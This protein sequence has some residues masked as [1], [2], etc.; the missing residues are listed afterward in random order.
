MACLEGMAPFHVPDAGKDVQTWYKVFGDLTGS[1]VPL[2]ALHGGP[3]IHSAYMAPLADLASHHNI[4]VVLYDQVGCG[5]S[6]RLAHKNGDH[7]FWTV[8]LFEREL[9]NLIQHLGIKQFDLLGHSWGG[10]LG[11]VYA[12]KNPPGLRKL[13]IVSSPA[14]LQTWLQSVYS[15]LERIP[16][17]ER[18]DFKRYEA[19]GNFDAPEY[20]AACMLFYTRHLCRCDPWPEELDASMN[21]LE[22]D[23]TVYGTM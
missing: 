15:L 11:S 22:E 5:N 10:M 1:Q 16:E 12:A 23:A 18:E 14:S 9:D 17:K 2:I 20:K 8:E 21:A 4:P 7:T 6:T 19:E 13:V 3:G